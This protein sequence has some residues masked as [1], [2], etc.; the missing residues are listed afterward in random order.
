M[1]NILNT[2]ACVSH[3]IFVMQKSLI[4]VQGKSQKQLGFLHWNRTSFGDD[5]G[6][7]TGNH[8]GY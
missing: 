4:P 1:P 6:A 8:A 2:C 7:L 3:S 5:H